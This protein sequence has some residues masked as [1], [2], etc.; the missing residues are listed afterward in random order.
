MII[1]IV[2]IISVIIVLAAKLY[3]GILYLGKKLL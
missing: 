2:I 3:T 1:I